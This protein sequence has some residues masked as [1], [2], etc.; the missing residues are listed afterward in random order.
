MRAGMLLVSQRAV[1]LTGISV[2]AGVASS[3]VKHM[4]VLQI[5]QQLAWPR[6][7]HVKHFD[8]GRHF[9]RRIVDASF[10]LFGKLNL[11]HGFEKS[12]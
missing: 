10:V 9:A 3:I 1:G 8:L 6:L 7:R 12:T 4:A 5:Y 2:R 11:G